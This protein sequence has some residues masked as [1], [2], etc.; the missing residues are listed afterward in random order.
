[1]PL[2]LQDHATGDHEKSPSK[3]LYLFY[4]R[5]PLNLTADSEI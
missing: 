2:T 3:F 5:R 4:K 1:M